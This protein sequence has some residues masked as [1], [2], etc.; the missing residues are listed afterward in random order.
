M[1]TEYW[2]ITTLM[3]QSETKSSEKSHAQKL[4]LYTKFTKKQYL[5]LIIALH[6]HLII[7]LIFIQGK[8][9]SIC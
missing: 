1:I 8:L 3:W 9:K 2:Y 7:A 5:Q 6:T 4:Y